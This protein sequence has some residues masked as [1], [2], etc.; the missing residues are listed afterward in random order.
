MEM[1]MIIA[2]GMQP[3]Q[4]LRVLEMLESKVDAAFKAEWAR[5]VIGKGLV[6]LEMTAKKVRSNGTQLKYLAGDGVSIADLCLIPQ[7]YNARRFN[8]TH[9]HVLQLKWL[10]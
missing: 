2:S 4:N 3:L 6:S 8:G 1:A 10:C 7:L 5:S 9:A